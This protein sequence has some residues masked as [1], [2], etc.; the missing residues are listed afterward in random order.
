MRDTPGHDVFVKN[1]VP[2]LHGVD[3]VCLVVSMIE[4]EFRA[5]IVGLREKLQLV[6]SKGI[7]NIVVVANKMDMVGWDRGVYKRNMIAIKRLIASVFGAEYSARYVP[8]N[9]MLGIGLLDIT[10]CPS[11]YSGMSVMEYILGFGK[12]S[13]AIC[14]YA[15]SVTPSITFKGNLVISETF[16]SIVLPGTVCTAIVARK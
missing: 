15:K 7:K 11:W 13:D 8:T 5:S 1:V 6:R 4:R 2:A 12:R 14:G 16:E 9:C 10:G 3:S